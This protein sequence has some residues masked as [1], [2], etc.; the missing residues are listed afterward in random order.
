ERHLGP[1]AVREALGAPVR[2]VRDVEIPDHLVDPLLER[3]ALEPVEPRVIGNVLARGEQRVEPRAVWQRAD[4]TARTETVGDHVDAVDVRVT[5]VG[6]ENG[7]ED[8]ER[9]RLAGAVRPQQPGDPAVA[10]FEAD[11]AHGP[12]FAERLADPIH[13]DHGAGP[14]KSRK[15]GM[16]NWRPFMQVRTSSMPSN[17]A[18]STNFAIASG[19]QVR[20]SWPWP[21]CSPTRCR[22]RV[23]PTAASS[24]NS[25]GVIGSASPDSSSTGVSVASGRRSVGSR[26]PSGHTAH[27][28][29]KASSCSGPM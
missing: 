5:R 10:G 12:D 23:M 8:A 20:V 13:P 7:V 29:C 9:R 6:L 24:A 26:T 21:W 25:G 19:M 18:V 14:V 2:E 28:A 27:I 4:A 1:L 3:V 17:D 22:C 11:V 16:A 15:K